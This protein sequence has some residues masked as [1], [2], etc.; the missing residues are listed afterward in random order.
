MKTIFKTA[1]LSLAC[2][3]PLVSCEDDTRTLR[4]ETT[5]DVI[6]SSVEL[7]AAN[8]EKCADRQGL[9]TYYRCSVRT[10]AINYQV[11]N[12]GMV[13]CYLYDG[14]AQAQLPSVRHYENAQNQFWTRTIDYEYYNGGVTFY[15]TDSDFAGEKPGVLTF[16]LM[17]AF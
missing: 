7:T 12:G 5:D 1:V 2:V 14:N 15:V 3:L 8:W 16:R 11:L 17:V 6:W 9:N 4:N 13:N 10:S